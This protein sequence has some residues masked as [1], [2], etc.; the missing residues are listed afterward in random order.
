M[1]KGWPV[2]R[3]PAF[4]VY[5]S[6]DHSN[7]LAGVAVVDLLAVVGL[8]SPQPVKTAKA[9]ATTT[10]LRIFFMIKDPLKEIG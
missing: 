2:R 6:G 1:K 4:K 5:R 7:Y 8:E 10:K 3:Q 9:P